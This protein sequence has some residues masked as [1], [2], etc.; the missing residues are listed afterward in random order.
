MLHADDLIA[1]FVEKILNNHPLT[2]AKS[3]KVSRD[4]GFVSDFIADKVLCLTNH[5]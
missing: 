3:I 2:G 1:S 5:G 4:T